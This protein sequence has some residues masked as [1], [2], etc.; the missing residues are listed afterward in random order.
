[1]TLVVLLSSSFKMLLVATQIP[2]LICSLLGVL[3]I[4][5]LRGQEKLQTKQPTIDFFRNSTVDEHESV[6]SVLESSSIS[7]YT[8]R[9]CAEAP[10]PAPL[11]ASFERS[12]ITLFACP[13]Y[14]LPPL[15]FATISIAALLY[16]ISTNL[17]D[18][19]WGLFLVVVGLL[20]HPILSKNKKTCIS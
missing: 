9:L 19:C 6:A 5:V 8:P 3:G 18:A 16:T 13:F 12:L 1:L 4:M 10:S 7:I 11:S 17:Y 14:P 15:L 2:V 20:L